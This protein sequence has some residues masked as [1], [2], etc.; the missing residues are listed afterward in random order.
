MLDEDPFGRGRAVRKG[1]LG[2]ISKSVGPKLS[3]ARHSHEG[4]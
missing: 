4:V 3:S 2:V 1:M